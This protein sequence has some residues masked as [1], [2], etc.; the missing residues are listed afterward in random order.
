[1]FWLRLVGQNAA[2]RKKKKKSYY[3]F[4]TTEESN[5]NIMYKSQ[6]CYT[7][8]SIIGNAMIYVHFFNNGKTFP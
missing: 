1:M 5:Y 8:C 6:Y 7:I 4:T 3:G 2:N